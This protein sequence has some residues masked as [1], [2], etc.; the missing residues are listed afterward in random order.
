[1]SSFDMYQD[2]FRNLIRQIE[3][4]LHQDK[5]ADDAEES[6]SSP[7]I[8]DLLG[9]CQELIPQMEVE[10]RA[11]PDRST[12][13]D[14]KDM[15]QACKLQLVSYKALETQTS[16]TKLWDEA[17]ERNYR[18]ETMQLQDQVGRQNAQ[19]DDAL[20]SIRETELVGSEITAELARNRATFENSHGNVR[21]ISSMAEQA[22]G[23]IK[24]MS[25]KW[26]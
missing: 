14:R 19:L 24:S 20:R 1:M 17:T 18:R 8:S 10:I 21:S 6:S 25:R 26:W 13:Q 16:S 3:Q 9:N 12:R 4:R 15:L 11:T 5:E 23:L 22:N 7:S 2:E